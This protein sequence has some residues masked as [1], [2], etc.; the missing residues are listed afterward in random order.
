MSS[1]D[2]VTSSNISVGIVGAGGFIGS[3]LLGD[4][5]KQNIYLRPFTREDSVLDKYNE[6]NTDV[7]NL[8]VLIWAASGVNPY[9]AEQDHSKKYEE[10][11][12]WEIVLKEISKKAPN[13]RIVYLSSGG[14]TYSGNDS[15]FRENS[16]AH[17]TNAYGHMKIQ[18]ES[19]LL[20]QNQ[21]NQIL[22][23]SNVYGPGQKIGRGQGVIAEWIH[24]AINENALRIYGPLESYRDYIYIDDVVWAIKEVVLREVKTNIYNVGSGEPVTLKSL[25]TIMNHY[26][27]GSLSTLE[28]PQRSFDRLGYVLN[29]DKLLDETD[30]KQQVEIRA[31]VEQTIKFELMKRDKE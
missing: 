28:M 27:A 4:L 22:R 30:W 23:L 6:L 7:N 11:K 26:F 10:L 19:L 25:Y 14:C 8:D 16:P 29:I 1:Y 12:Y 15:P 3:H 24:S 9:S 31:G 18:I 20:K 5:R 13:L 21:A 2:S 17:G